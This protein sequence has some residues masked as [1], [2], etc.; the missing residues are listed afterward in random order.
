MVQPIFPGVGTQSRIAQTLQAESDLRLRQEALNRQ[1]G[2]DLLGLGLG[3]SL[4]LSQ[5]REQAQRAD[6]DRQARSIEAGRAQAA[7]AS[8]GAARLASQRNIA[9]LGATT[10]IE[11]ARIR[12]GAAAERI[13]LTAEEKFA[14]SNL[15]AQIQ[16]E[17]DERLSQQVL[18]RAA[19][20]SELRGGLEAATFE[21]EEAALADPVRRLEDRAFLINDSFVSGEAQGL[22]DAGTAGI[23][24]ADLIKQMV[25]ANPEIA[26]Q[27]RSLAPIL[28]RALI[29][30]AEEQ[31]AL[32]DP[33]QR[34][35]ERRERAPFIQPDELPSASPFS[36][37][38][39]GLESRRREQSFLDRLDPTTGIQTPLPQGEQLRQSIRDQLVGAPRRGGPERNLPSDRFGSGLRRLAER[40]VRDP[41]ERLLNPDRARLRALQQAAGPVE[42]EVIERNGQFFLILPGGQ[43]V[44]IPED[45]PD[46]DRGFRGFTGP[47]GGTF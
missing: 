30:Q 33:A 15:E 18:G 25:L 46:P 27:S 38:P 3:T 24:A 1:S 21:R 6:A 19:A 40:G 4:S 37:A 23:R 45:R 10:D 35:A 29:E 8:A 9:Q 44:P 36:N 34:A 12:E 28:E 14:Q 13:G 16:E 31:D 20:E 5:L 41:I 43:V 2:Q 39:G 22:I 47:T 11:L 32:L 42:G 17:R 26:R 7:A